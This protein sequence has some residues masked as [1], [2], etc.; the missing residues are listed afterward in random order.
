M[1]RNSLALVLILSMIFV[2]C[3]LLTG[4][5]DD[6]GDH[7]NLEEPE[8]TVEYLSG[9]YAEQLLRDGGESTLGTIE[10]EKDS[11]GACSLTVH[12]MVIVESSISD[13]GYYI[14]DKNISNTVPLSSQAMATYIQSPDSPPEVIDL[15]TFISKA[16]KDGEK[17]ASKKKDS[18]PPEKLYN[19]YIIGGSALLLLAKELPR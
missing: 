16:Q 3:L 1:K 7:D 14:A 12:S 19:V 5:E 4:C 8:I 11:E 13:D 18:D 10:I 15:E 17:A 9:E 2:L 6:P